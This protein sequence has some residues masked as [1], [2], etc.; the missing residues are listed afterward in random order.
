VC[1][2]VFVC[3]QMCRTL[4]SICKGSD[5]LLYLFEHI[6]KEYEPPEGTHCVF[7]ALIDMT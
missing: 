5:E 3:V 4:K 1:L 6:T 2:C 7:L